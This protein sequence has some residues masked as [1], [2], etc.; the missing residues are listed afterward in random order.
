[1]AGAEAKPEPLDD[2]ETDRL[3]APLEAYSHLVVA[4]SGGSDSICLM[5]LA[6]QWRERCKAAPR[7]SVLTVDHGLRTQSR[8]EAEQV[9]GWARAVGLDHATLRW[10]K[11]K[12]MSG[13]QDAARRARYQLMSEWCAGNGAQGIVTG[14]TLDD[15]AETVMMRLAR[16]SGVDGLSGMSQSSSEPWCVLRPLLTV[17]RARLQASLRA[18]NHSW[19]DDPGN[20][21]EGFE[22]IRVRKVLRDL[23]F[24]GLGADAIGLS[25]RRLSRVRSALNHYVSELASRAVTLD[26][27][28]KVLIDL[29]LL[30]N[31]PE[32]LQIRLLSDTIRQ[33]GGHEYPR[34]AAV[35]RI[36]E[37]ICDGPGR[38]KTLGGCRISRRK[39]E[40]VVARE[41]GRR[42]NEPF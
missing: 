36:V 16:G 33:V 41:P 6:N 28:G 11:P 29:A 31:A 23:Q 19:I 27:D 37:W 3:F 30:A 7:L 14:H 10:T 5:L 1:M 24:L 26:D 20:D 2:A 18:M 34:L 8:N 21:D 39:R 38:A 13:V 17:T 9:A 12:P 4:V 22:R 35:E 32:E 25:A 42:A 40:I 15:Q